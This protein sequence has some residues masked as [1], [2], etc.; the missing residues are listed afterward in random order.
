MCVCV[1]VYIYTF[2]CIYIY[3][4]TFRYAN[5]N[6]FTNA[7]QAPVNSFEPFKEIKNKQSKQN[8]RYK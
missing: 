6:N 5:K 3:I 1:C 2:I 7:K 8:R 4:F